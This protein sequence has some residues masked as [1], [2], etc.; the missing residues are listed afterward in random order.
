MQ[1]FSKSD[2]LASKPKILAKIAS[3]VFI[4]PTDTIYG[5]GCDAT[6]DSSVKRIRELKGRDSKPFSVIAPSIS[7]IKDNCVL[8]DKAKSWLLKLPGPYTLILP[9]KNPKAVCA[10][11]NMGLNSLGVRIPDHWISELVASFGKP[12]ITTSV[13]VAGKPPAIKLEQLEL[14]AVEFIIYEGEKLGKPSTV[15]D[16]I[17]GEQIIRH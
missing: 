11:T 3:E 5:I 6:N 13:N 12:I 10:Q 4:Y 8:S 1:V 9:L 2:V 15:V 14:F 7:W 17:K 16:L